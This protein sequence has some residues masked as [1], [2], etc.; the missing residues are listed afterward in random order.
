MLPCLDPLNLIGLL[1]LVLAIAAHVRL[2]T[3]S[4]QRQREL[5]RIMEIVEPNG[6]DTAALRAKIE[7]TERFQKRP[8]RT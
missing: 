1:A 8:P 6:P 7:R 3:L 2:N 4:L 5:L